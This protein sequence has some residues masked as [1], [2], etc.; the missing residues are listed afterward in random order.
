MKRDFEPSLVAVCL[1]DFRKMAGSSLFVFWNL[2]TL[3]RP[4]W[5]FGC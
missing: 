2:A 3:N 5:L 4:W 1:L